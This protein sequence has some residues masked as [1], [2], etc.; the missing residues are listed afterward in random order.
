M[1]RIIK[2]E[3]RAT[4]FIKG[5]PICGEPHEHLYRLTVKFNFDKWIDFFEL[6]KLLRIVVHEY[7]CNLGDMT[8]EKLVKHIRK[9]IITLW[10]QLQIDILQ[11]LEVELF[12][13][14]RFGVIA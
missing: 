4:H 12:E 7:A 3:F 9:A 6:E 13:N 2:T 8:A 10:N 14:E 5:H 11:G 1:W